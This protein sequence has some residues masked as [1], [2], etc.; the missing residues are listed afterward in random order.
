[1]SKTELSWSSPTPIPSLL[2]FVFP[3]SVKGTAVSPADPA[4]NLG[5]GLA[6]LLSSPLRDSSAGLW[7]YLQNTPQSVPIPPPPLAAALCQTRA[8][9]SW[10]SL[11]P[12]RSIYPKGSHLTWDKPTRLPMAPRPCDPPALPPYHLTSAPAP[13]PGSCASATRAFFPFLHGLYLGHCP[14]GFP[15]LTLPLLLD[16]CAT[17][18]PRRQRPCNPQRHHS[19]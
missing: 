5:V 7:Y 18:T 4:R 17:V 13:H 19:I 1:M 9:S 12:V 16:L 2:L 3:I 10:V 8:A 6:S 14:R 11:P 15:R